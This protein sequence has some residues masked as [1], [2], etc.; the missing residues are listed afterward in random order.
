MT[1]CLLQTWLTPLLLLVCLRVSGSI[2]EEVSEHCSHMIGNGH[3]QFLQQLVS[4]RLCLFTFS[5]WGKLG[6][7]PGS[8]VR[9]EGC[10]QRSTAVQ[11]VIQ[12][13]RLA[14]LM[15]FSLTFSGSGS[16]TYTQP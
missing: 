6:K 1:H 11:A 7:E 9:G 5:P 13:S 10:R 4:T 8:R 15:L 2:T 14:P 3:L 12:G 16:L